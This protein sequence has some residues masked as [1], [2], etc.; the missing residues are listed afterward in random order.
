[1]IGS[2]IPIVG[3]IFVGILIIIIIDLYYQ[4]SILSSRQDKFD[5]LEEKVMSTV[6]AYYK[7]SVRDK[8][9]FIGEIEKLYDKIQELEKNQ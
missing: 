9:F 6:S 8:T 1:M 5:N 4:N 7:Q 2:L 3:G